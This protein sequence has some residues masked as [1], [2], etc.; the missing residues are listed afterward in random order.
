MMLDSMLLMRSR[1][2]LQRGTSAL[3]PQISKNAESSGFVVRP[4][5][6][7]AKKLGASSVDWSILPLRNWPL[8]LFLGLCEIDGEDAVLPARN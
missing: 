6:Q 7:A 2:G 1:V 4:M 3:F 5:L 8:H